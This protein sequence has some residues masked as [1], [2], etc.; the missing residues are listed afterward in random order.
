MKKD[1]RTKSRLAVKKET[2]RLLDARVL[3]PD[4]LMQV[5]GGAPTGG[6]TK[7]KYSYPC[8]SS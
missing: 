5:H 6:G 4:D 7:Q 3:S 8:T 1:R 2:L